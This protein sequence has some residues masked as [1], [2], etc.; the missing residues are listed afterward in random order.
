V[1]ELFLT[2][3]AA[4]A[5]VVLPAQSWAE[6]EGTFTSGERRVQRFYPAIPAVGESRAD[7]QILAQIG[8]RLDLGQA[9]FAASLVFRDIAQTVPQY[10]DLDYRRLARVEEQWPVVGG[11]D[12][13]YG[14]T[15][16]DNRSGLGQQWP[17]AAESSAA[18]SSVM[19][20]FDVPET[21]AGEI[22]GLALVQSAALYTSGTLLPH[23]P[24][25]SQR[26]ASPEVLLHPDDARRLAVSHGDLVA[27]SANG[28]EL[29]VKAHVN[30]RTP[31]GLAVLRGA[32][33]PAH[34]AAA[35][36]VPAEIR[37]VEEKAPSASLED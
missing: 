1:Q 34:Q 17:A 19:A 4:L 28:A 24:L 23:S 21:R 6:R 20:L 8:E 7:W 25:L 9:P 12:L 29:S 10:G 36:L 22:Q 14:G 37:K 11:S 30:E 27:L 16:Y 18:V 2:P 15:A 3:S 31:A 13:Y 35:G 26:L 32:S 33:L 5:D